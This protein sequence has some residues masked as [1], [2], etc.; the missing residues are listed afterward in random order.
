MF[1]EGLDTDVMKMGVAKF[2]LKSSIFWK[3]VP[4]GCHL[5][6]DQKI[7]FTVDKFIMV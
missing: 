3:I 1:I 5:W 4:G 2:P 7:L 6:P